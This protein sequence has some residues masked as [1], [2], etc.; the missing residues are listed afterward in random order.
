MK[1]SNHTMS[2]SNSNNTTKQ[3]ART[4][5]NSNV[6]FGNKRNT[7]NIGSGDETDSEKYETG[8]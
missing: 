8:R 5:T 4:A 6:G 7:L 3:L 2:K 1:L